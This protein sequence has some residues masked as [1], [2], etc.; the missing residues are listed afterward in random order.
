MASGLIDP[1]EIT[2]CACPRIDRLACAETRGRLD[3]AGEPEDCPCACHD[4][5][6]E[7]IREADDT[8]EGLAAMERAK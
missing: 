4:A 7:Q 5:Y 8:A 3:E 1:R 2:G 6:E